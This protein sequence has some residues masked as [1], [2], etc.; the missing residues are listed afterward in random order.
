MA[1]ETRESD[2]ERKYRLDGIDIRAYLAAIHFSPAGPVD[3]SLWPAG[4]ER[5]AG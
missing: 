5:P 3:R 4:R 2:D 1:T